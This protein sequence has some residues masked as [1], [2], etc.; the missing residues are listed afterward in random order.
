MDANQLKREDLALA[1]GLIKTQIDPN[2]GV[3]HAWAFLGLMRGKAVRQGNLGCSQAIANTKVVKLPD[4]TRDQPKNP[5]AE[6]NPWK[7]SS[8]AADIPPRINKNKLDKA[9]RKAFEDSQASA[10]KRTRA[11]VVVQDGWVIAEQYADGITPETPL[12]GWSMTK[13]LTHA[14]IG[15]AVKNGQLRLNEPLSLPEWGNDN[16]CLLYT[17]PSPRD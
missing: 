13:S 2:D 15:I 6:T 8:D 16:D 4:Q 11:I 7:I 1:Q 17:S 10:P 3:V 9:I 12:I 5:V 14:L